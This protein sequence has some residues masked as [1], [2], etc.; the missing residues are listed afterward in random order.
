MPNWTARELALRER[1][2]QGEAVVVS[3]RRGADTARLRDWCD[4]VGLLVRVDRRSAYGNPFPMDDQQDQTE[5]TAVCERYDE[6][7]AG[8]LDLLDGLVDLRG[9]ALACWCAP[10][11]CHADTLAR[12]ANDEDELQQWRSGVAQVAQN[13]RAEQ[14]LLGTIPMTVSPHK[15]K[16]ATCAT[17]PGQRTGQVQTGHT[18]AATGQTATGQG[19]D[20]PLVYDLPPRADKAALAQW[21][22]RRPGESYQAWSER[23]DRADDQTRRRRP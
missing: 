10:E 8:R 16:S 21:L 7:L 13:S 15:A 19:L 22:E 9:K 5:R 17:T 12:L 23:F 4:E 20:R 1:L 3:L 11:R 18:A 14:T 2:V 6:H